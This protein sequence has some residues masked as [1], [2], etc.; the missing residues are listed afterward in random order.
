MRV[1]KKK[2]PVS[3]GTKGAKKN[4]LTKHNTIMRILYQ[5]PLHRFQAEV[6]GDHCLPSTI[7]SLKKQHG[8]EFPR[9]WVKVPNRFG[10][11]TSVMEYSTSTEDKVI[12]DGVWGVVE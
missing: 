7:S 12:I 6:E 8:L 1:N 2:P 9:R 11:E 3:D 4:I 5:R 10:G